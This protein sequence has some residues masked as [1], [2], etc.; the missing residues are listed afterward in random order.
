V[1][2]SVYVSGLPGIGKTSAVRHLAK[3]RPDEFVRMS[4]GE[5]LRD[6]MT[7]DA[8]VA[9]FRRKASAGVDRAAIE[10]AT[11]ML[12]QRIQKSEQ[13]VLIDSHAV[14]PTPEGLRATPD[15]PERVAAFGY[16]L[17]THLSVASVE[18]RVLRNSGTEGRTQ[19]SMPDLAAAET[20]QLSIVA[21]YASLCDCPLYIVSALGEVDEVADRL[22]RAITV[23]LDWVSV[24]AHD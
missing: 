11:A 8:T 12:A 17:I 4:F 2:A 14:T 10:R 22:A 18:E 9:S 1:N 3:I 6:V 5:A 13:V 23:G 24:D 7:P 20:V 19:M 16:S 21:R 15:T